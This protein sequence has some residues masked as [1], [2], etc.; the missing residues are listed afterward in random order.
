MRIY[1][2]AVTEEEVITLFRKT[3][4]LSPPAP[5]NITTLNGHKKVTL[6]WERVFGANS[7]N[8]Y[9]STNPDISKTNYEGKI[10]DIT[11]TTYVHNNLTNSTKYYYLITT[12][13]NEGESDRGFSTVEFEINNDTP[14]DL[15][16]SYFFDRNANDIGSNGNDATV[17]EAILTED[18]WGN[19]ESAYK[20]DGIND[21]MEVP[22]NPTLSLTEDMTVST[23]VYVD[24]FANGW[25]SIVSKSISDKDKNYE[26]RYYAD[27]RI[28]FNFYDG[29]NWAGAGNSW[30]TVVNN[31]TMQKN[32]WYLV[33]GIKKG[34]TVSIYLNDTLIAHTTTNFTPKA[35]TSPLRIGYAGYY[36]RHNGK[37]DDVRIYNRALDENEV[38]NLFKAENPITSPEYVTDLEVAKITDITVTLQWTAIDYHG[39]AASYDLR[40]STSPIVSDNFDQAAKIDISAPQAVGNIETVTL[41]VDSDTQYYFAI[42]VIDSA[43]DISE[44]SNMTEVKT[45]DITSPANIDT[46]EAQ[47]TGNGEITLNWTA[48]GDDGGEGQATLYEIRYSKDP[49]TEENF[50][51]GIL[52]TDTLKPKI[53]GVVETFKIADLNDNNF[54]YFAI[55]TTDEVVNSSGLSNIANINNQYT[56]EISGTIQTGVND[57]WGVGGNV[58]SDVI[59]VNGYINIPSGVTLTI[60]P[61]TVIK[62]YNTCGYR[63]N[64]SYLNVKGKLLSNGTS[65]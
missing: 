62:A 18:R 8:L 36:L 35:N 41:D 15:V 57:V 1:N 48:P 63:Q 6:N 20:F 33:T 31:L 25:T 2:R 37:I 56:I 64:C 22:D 40:Q 49:I 23:W 16:G 34:N 47:V 7:Y 5:T 30:G 29:T 61:G 4:T 27:G 10:T 55:K 44:I 9:W 19:P 28:L 11:E 13:N 17:H 24:N 52:A 43:G 59:I 51:D 21:Y 26:L 58:N 32:E 65:L 3:N 50:K 38:T 60:N 53:G 14:T 46:L 42:K 39:I 45:P 12:V 54:Y